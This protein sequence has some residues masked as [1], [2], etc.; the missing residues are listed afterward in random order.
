M[1]GQF[2]LIHT[3]RQLEIP[4]QLDNW[5]TNRASVKMFCQHKNCLPLYFRK[6]ITC[7]TFGLSRIE[8]GF[9][10]SY[11]DVYRWVM[12]DCFFTSDIFLKIFGN[13]SWT[14]TYLWE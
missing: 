3:I 8:K 12:T 4:T 9:F 2:F 1:K 11:K 7:L 5:F 10:V 6:T 13:N 14:E